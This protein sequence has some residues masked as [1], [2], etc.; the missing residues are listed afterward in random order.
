MPIVLKSNSFLE[1]RGLLL[2][3]DTRWYGVLYPNNIV[4][5]NKHN[6][7]YGNRGM[8]LEHLLNL[9]NSYYEEKNLALIYKKPTP[10]G[11]VDV[12]YSLKGKVIDKAYFKAPST[13]DYSGIYLGKYI[14]FEAKETKHK[15]SFPLSNI[16]EH[17]IL[18]IRKVIQH[19]GIVFLIVRIQSLVYLLD[20]Q[21]FLDFID[22]NNRQSIPYSYFVEQGHKIKERIDPP[23]DYLSIVNQI[24]FG[25][26]L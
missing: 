14:E 11:I 21:K 17:Q 10:I 8:D 1:K 16:H 26:M 18:H 12:H 24:Y 6:T 13:L 5:Q 3:N 22:H 2:Y 20:G 19:G 4:K 9:S 15:T 23:L 7:S 25:G